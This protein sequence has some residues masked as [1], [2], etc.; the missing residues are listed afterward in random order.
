M[1]LADLA[2]EFGVF[3]HEVAML[4]RQVVLSVPRIPSS[5]PTRDLPADGVDRGNTRSTAEE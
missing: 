5:P 4:R 3:R 2:I 1:E